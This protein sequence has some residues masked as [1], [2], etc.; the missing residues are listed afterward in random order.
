VGVV[1]IEQANDDT[2]VEVDQSHSSRR[3]SMSCLA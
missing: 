2:G 1:G 3:V